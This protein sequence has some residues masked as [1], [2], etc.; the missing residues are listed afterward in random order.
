MDLSDKIA[1]DEEIGQR[2][3]ARYSA[4][5]IAGLADEEAKQYTDSKHFWKCLHDI[6]CAHVP[7]RKQKEEADRLAK[8]K[9]SDGE[10]QRFGSEIMPYGEFAGKRIDDVPLERLEW[11]A[12]QRFTDELRRYLRSDRVRTERQE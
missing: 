2:I 10:A 7:C 8:A 11:Y 9:M 12:D 6:V 4:E 5:L 1:S 3:A